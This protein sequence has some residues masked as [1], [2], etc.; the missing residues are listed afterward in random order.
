MLHRL[1]KYLPQDINIM[2]HKGGKMINLV[3]LR[4]RVSVFQKIPLGLSKKKKKH[5]SIVVYVWIV[6]LRLPSFNTWSTA[7][8]AVWGGCGS[9]RRSN[10]TRRMKWVT[11]D[12]PWGFIARLYF[13]FTPAFWVGMQSNQPTS[14][15]CQPCLLHS[16]PRWTL[17][18][19]KPKSE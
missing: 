11:G 15:S 10:L 4:V 2:I 19:K 17:S 1:G 13:L 3:S 7:G 8:G 5:C 9:F 6:P 14:C 18:P 12:G 16:S